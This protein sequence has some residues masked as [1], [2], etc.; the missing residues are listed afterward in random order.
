MKIVFD[1]EADNLLVD[2]TKLHVMIA[3][4]VGTG[5]KYKYYGDDTS[6]MELFEKA[7]LLIAHNGL[8]YDVPLLEKLYG[9]VPPKTVKVADTL[10][11]SQILDYM[12]FGFSGHSLA[13]WGEHF[14]FEKIDFRQVC[15]DLGYIDKKSPRG[16]EFREYV[17]EMDPYCERDVDLL[18]MIFVALDAEYTALM[19]KAPQIKTY[20]QAEH[21]VAKWSGRAEL[22]GWP[23]DID[24]AVKLQGILKERLDIITEKLE[25][26]LGTKCVIVD[27]IPHS[28]DKDIRAETKYPVW[29]N[30]G[31]Y[32]ANTAKWFNV[33]PE[34]GM[35]EDC[36]VEGG[37]C[38]I[39]FEKLKLS[40]TEDVKLFLF[41]QGWQPTEYNWKTDPDDY[42]KKIRMAPKITEDSLVLL[43]P[44]GQLYTEYLTLVSRYGVVNG[45]VEK[46]R[47]GHLHGTCMVVGTPSM[48]SRH[49][50]IANVPSGEK[51][52]DG[53]EESMYGEAMRRLFMSKPGYT[54]VGCDS[55][56]NQARGLAHY[57]ADEEFIKILLHEDIHLY[58][59][60]KIN[61]VLEGM[62]YGRPCSRAQAKRIL[63]AFLFGAGGGKLWLYVFGVVDDANGA[64]LKNG[65]IAAVPGFKDLVDKLKS[66]YGSTKKKGYGYIPSL[67]GNRIY[68]DSTH[69]LLVYL[70][71]ACEK[72]TCSAALMLAVRR[73]EQEGIEYQPLIMYHDEFNFMVKNED[74]ER[75]KEIGVWAFQEGPKK[76]GV[77]IM[78]GSGATGDTWYDIH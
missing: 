6:W 12:R 28:A 49:N 35:Y 5:K 34:S 69:K 39:S 31:Y 61:D 45:W 58:N 24:G 72:I 1:I 11:M 9:W 15:I 51:D 63:Y 29:T 46:Y 60:E 17:P 56:G 48:R 50:V 54:L 23:F 40:S 4:V 57:L 37:Y 14:G 25:D 7:S 71:Q 41:R 62:G 55:S 70:L 75:A 19:R 33:S 26:Q 66:I 64:R 8:M 73:L 2:A 52:D 44:E 32:H 10:I 78:D 67:A 21:A 65:F 42:R 16:E 20:M 53:N 3:K 43:G 76:F 77:T 47:E 68:I 74:A 27:R 13:V 30:E 18:E 38:R 36:I 22:K 59:M